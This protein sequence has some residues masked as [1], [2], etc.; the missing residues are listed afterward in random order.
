MKFQS[1]E[2]WEADECN[3]CACVAGRVQC[4]KTQCLDITCAPNEVLSTADG[5]CCPQ[6][7]PPHHGK[8]ENI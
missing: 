5:E 2:Q 7:M 6:C 1:G 8:Q 3:T 4:L